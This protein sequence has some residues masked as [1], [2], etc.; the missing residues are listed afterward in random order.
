MDNDN[1]NDE[2]NDADKDREKVQIWSRCCKQEYT[3]MLYSDVIT[4]IE[5]FLLSH[6]ILHVNQNQNRYENEK[7]NG[8][9]AVVNVSD[10]D[11]DDNGK[12]CKNK[13]KGSSTPGEDREKKEDQENK[14]EKGDNDGRIR[15]LKEYCWNSLI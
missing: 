5:N 8:E 4:N 15:D 1:N 9:K 14:K 3:P 6:Q 7:Q 2:D 12:F 13:D 11:G 10:D